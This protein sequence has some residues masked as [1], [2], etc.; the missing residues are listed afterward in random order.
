MFIF[1]NNKT[2]I[3][4]IIEEKIEN[5]YIRYFVEDPYFFENIE[6]N[7]FILMPISYF[8]E[9]DL[10]FKSTELLFSPLDVDSSFLEFYVETKLYDN[11]FTKEKIKDMMINQSSSMKEERNKDISLKNLEKKA[12]LDMDIKYLYI[13]MTQ[14]SANEE[15]H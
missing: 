4:N 9:N 12:A 3:A 15:I 10:S 11:H 13:L 14:P 7:R 6:E 5:D 2:M 1:K 8:I